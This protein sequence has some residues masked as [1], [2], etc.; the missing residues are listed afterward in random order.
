MAGRWAGAL[1]LTVGAWAAGPIV[2]P[3][4]ELTGQLWWR[5]TPGPATSPIEPWDGPSPV[6]LWV[7]GH[8]LTDE[9]DQ[10]RT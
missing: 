5:T 9:P 4:H 6:V 8:R 7:L 3:T 10:S 1:S 2:R